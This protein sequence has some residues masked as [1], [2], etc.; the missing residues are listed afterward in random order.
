MILNLYNSIDIINGLK[1]LKLN[2]GDCIFIHSSIKSLG[3]YEDQKFPNLLNVIKNALFEIIGSGGTIVVPTFNFDFAKGYDFDVNK[4]PSHLMGVF[5]EFIR[6]NEASNRTDHPFHS[7]SI[8]G[9]N[10]RFISNLKSETE[11][12]SGSAFDY[13]VKNNCKILFLGDCF[14]ETFFH[15]AENNEEVPYRYW[16]KFT[17]NVIRDGKKRF[18][19]IKYFARNIDLI[20][21]PKID[22]DKLQQFLDDQNIFNYSFIKKKRIMACNSKKNLNACTKKLQLNPL[23]FLKN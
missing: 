19:E 6:N 22:L 10:S 16:K 17:G 20:P 3:K 14:T 11:F 18:I 21:E 9:N 7:I 8:L 13:L 23:Y 12:S 5:S 15:I 2:K 1:G 4:T